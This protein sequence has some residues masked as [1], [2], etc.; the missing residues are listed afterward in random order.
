MM[1]RRCSNWR[2]GVVGVLVAGTLSL[3]GILSVAVAS[4]LDD[5]IST[6]TGDSIAAWDRLGKPDPNIGFILLRAKSLATAIQPGIISTPSSSAVIGDAAMSN[7]NSVVLGAGSRVSGDVILVDQSSG[8]K[9]Q[10]ITSDRQLSSGLGLDVLIDGTSGGVAADIAAAL[11]QNIAE[12]LVDSLSD[13]ISADVI[14]HISTQYDTQLTDDVID[15]INDSVTQGVSDSISG[16][17]AIQNAI[18]DSISQDLGQTGSEVDL[19]GIDSGIDTGS[20]GD[21]GAIVYGAG[22]DGSL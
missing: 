6:Y 13:S 2:H 4:D 11:A 12:Q 14:A 22:M 18:D 20:P 10:L 3:G 15:A 21:I 19:G 1:K 17:D 8:A 7:I 16:S 5:G 9:T